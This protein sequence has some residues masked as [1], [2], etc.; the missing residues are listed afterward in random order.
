MF[1]TLCAVGFLGRL[2]YEMIRSPV[3]SLF[4]KHIGAPTEVVGLLVA[5]VT[6]TGIFV[7]FPSGALADIFGFRRVMTSGMIVKASAPFLYLLVSTWPWL[8]ALRFYHG[9]STALYAPA[10]SAFVAKEY[11]HQRAGKLGIYSAWENAGVVLGPVL[12]AAAL[13]W[14]S[15]SKAFIISG[16]IGTAALLAIFAL[17]ADAP[18]AQHLKARDVIDNVLTG[19]KQIAGDHAIRVVSLVEATMYMGVGT[20]QAYLPLYAVSVHRSVAEIGLFFGAQGVASIVGRPL[21]GKASDTTGRRPLIIAGV[22]FCAATLVLIP[23]TA[24]FVLLLLLNVFFGLGT[25]MVTPSTTAL[26]GDTVKRNNFGS[27][28]GVFGSLWD[29]GHAAGPIIAGFLITWLGYRNAFAIVGGIIII[30]LSIFVASRAVR[31]IPHAATS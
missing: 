2:S 12:G 23:F 31:E 10:A 16:I 13:T 8:L 6:I 22:L 17:R 20:L 19:A 26:I 14:F 15:F 7:K 5:A 28:M 18:V 27:A 29:T 1:L 4:A 11:P 3:V 30:A 25:G 24:N 9:L 21:W